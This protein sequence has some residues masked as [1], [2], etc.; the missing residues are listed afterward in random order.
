MLRGMLS[1]ADRSMAG[2][3]SSGGLK[4]SRYSVSREVSAHT[5]LLR[6]SKQTSSSI[7]TC[8]G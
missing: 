7:L 4:I 2:I 6:R 3:I 8:S 5:S 1:A